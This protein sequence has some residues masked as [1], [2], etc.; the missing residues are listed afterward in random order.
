MVAPWRSLAKPERVTIVAPDGSIRCQVSAYYAGNIFIIDDMKADLEP[1]D[2]LRRVLPNGKDDVYRV[3]D[4]KLFD[5]GRMP[6]H[7]QVKVSRKGNFA[8]QTGG[9]FINVSGPNAR[10]NI[11]STDNSTNTVRTGDVFADMRQ[12]IEAGVTDPERKAEIM[13][14]INEAESAKGSGGFLKAYQNIVGTA[15]DHLGVLTP[16][17]PALTGMLG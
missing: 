17:L 13:A 1:G 14:A 9:Y 4:P 7:Y 6:A 3:D 15:A 10:V 2:E 16:F 5:T 8:H 12:A 11:G